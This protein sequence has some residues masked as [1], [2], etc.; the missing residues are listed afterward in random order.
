[1]GVTINLELQHT[2]CGVIKIFCLGKKLVTKMY[3]KM[4][5]ILGAAA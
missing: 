4:K 2:L 5:T 1:M 3:A